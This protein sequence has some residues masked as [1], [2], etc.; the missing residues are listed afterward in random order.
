MPVDLKERA[1]W[2]DQTLRSLADPERQ[3]VTSGY[4]PTEMEILGV[5]A[6]KMRTVL[7]QLLKDLKG[8]G[9][10]A[11]LELAW[12]LREQGTHEARQV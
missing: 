12:L 1:E 10:E 6:P 7:R 11:V 5:S 2:A 9:A 8:E 3:R 4:F